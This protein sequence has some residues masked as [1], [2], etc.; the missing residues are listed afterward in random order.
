MSPSGLHGA[1][2]VQH[3]DVAGL[4]LNHQGVH[5][6]ASVGRHNNFIFKALFFW[7]KLKVLMGF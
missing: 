4:A 2:L 5:G 6:D 1:G 7:G 3:Q